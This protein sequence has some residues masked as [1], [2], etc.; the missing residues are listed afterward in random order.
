MTGHS[1]QFETL[2]VTNSPDFAQRFFSRLK[3]L[4]ILHQ[5]Y[6]LVPLENVTL[7]FSHQGMASRSRD[8]DYRDELWKNTLNTQGR[9]GNGVGNGRSN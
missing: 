1:M 8:E 4:R 5:S 6:R 2:D 3:S 9:F 7:C